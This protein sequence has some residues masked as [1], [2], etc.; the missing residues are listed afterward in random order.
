MLLKTVLGI[1]II[2]LNIIGL[3]FIIT[4]ILSLIKK[5]K[6]TKYQK[7]TFN[8]SKNFL[9]RKRQKKVDIQNDKILSDSDDILNTINI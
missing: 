8:Q 6:P 5:K 4:N 9:L 2:S 1:T 3:V 7:K